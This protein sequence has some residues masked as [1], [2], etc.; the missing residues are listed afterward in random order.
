MSLADWYRDGENVLRGACP[1]ELLAEGG[2]CEPIN[3]RGWTPD[4]DPPLLPAE[5]A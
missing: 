5:E 2:F 3:R 1:L 4:D